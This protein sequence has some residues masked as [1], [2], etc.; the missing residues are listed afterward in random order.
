M[1]FHVT[2]TYKY[3]IHLLY[4]HI[5]PAGITALVLLIVAVVAI[6]AGIW[7]VYYNKHVGIGYRAG[8]KDPGDIKKE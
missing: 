1:T 3:S 4:V 5:H 7:L 6:V 8:K 2:L